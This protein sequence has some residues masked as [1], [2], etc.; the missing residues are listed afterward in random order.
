VRTDRSLSPWQRCGHTENSKEIYDTHRVNA[1]NIEFRDAYE[2]TGL[3][4]L[5][6]IQDFEFATRGLFAA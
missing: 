1:V 3:I 5:P 4:D 6:L 2:I